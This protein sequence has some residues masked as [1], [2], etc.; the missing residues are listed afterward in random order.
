MRTISMFVL[1]S[2][3]FVFH[4]KL[5][6]AISIFSATIDFIM[7]SIFLIAVFSKK[8]Y[9]PVL[10]AVYSGIAVDITTQGTYINTGIYLFF[11]ILLGILVLFFKEHNVAITSISIFVMVAI[12]HLS[13]VFLL[14]VTRLSQSLS[15]VTFFHGLPSAIYSAVAGIGIYYL[16]K[17]LFS[18]SF[19]EEKNE[20]EGKYII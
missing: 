5:A 6:P 11:G 10:C 16:Y 20:N 17:W 15:L 4:I 12:K 1:S 18:F 2:I 13:L 3:L 9:P 14:Y 19:M 7:I 8:W